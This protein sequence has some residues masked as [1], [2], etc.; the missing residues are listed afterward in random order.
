MM[1]TESAVLPVRFL[2]T[3]SVPAGQ[4]CITGVPY[5][6]VTHLGKCAPATG[7]LRA[8]PPPGTIHPTIPLGPAEY[9]VRLA[10][11]ECPHKYSVGPGLC[12]RI[13]VKI[14]TWSWPVCEDRGETRDLMVNTHCLLFSGNVFL[15]F[16]V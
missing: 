12:V 3:P 16:S 1:S 15:L 10:M 2:P 5:Y 7:H 4:K 14:L 8:S 13:E 9:I 11:R 6:P